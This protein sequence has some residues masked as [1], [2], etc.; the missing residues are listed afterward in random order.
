MFL[1]NEI[2]L[3]DVSTS[4]W[5]NPRG[6]LRG[7]CGDER[8]RCHWQRPNLGLARPSRRQR[9]VGA[10]GA[11][12]GWKCFGALGPVGPLQVVSAP[13]IVG[14]WSV[15]CRKALLF[16]KT[17]FTPTDG[18]SIEPIRPLGPLG[19][20]FAQHRQTL[21]PYAERICRKACFLLELQSKACRIQL[22]PALTSRP[23]RLFSSGRAGFL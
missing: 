1:I 11:K 14:H 19:F 10:G 2:P 21:R 12:K 16:L 23:N 3:Y 9:P 22:P 8:S 17:P 5:N 18:S 4:D 7:Y 15:P 6:A 13:T 20:D